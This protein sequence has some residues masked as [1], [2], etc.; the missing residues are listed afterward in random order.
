MENESAQQPN[1]DQDQHDKW[2][3][4][5]SREQI[6]RLASRVAQAARSAEQAGKLSSK[7]GLPESEQ[8]K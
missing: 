8:M 4:S 3:A 2:L 6:S 5:R 7:S 1:L